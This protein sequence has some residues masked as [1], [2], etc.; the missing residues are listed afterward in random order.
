MKRILSLL[1]LLSFLLVQSVAA[2]DNKY[3]SAKNSKATHLSKQEIEENIILEEKVMTEDEYNK[4]TEE[5]IKK[6]VTYSNYEGLIETIYKGLDEVKDEIDITEYCNNIDDTD[7]NLLMSYYFSVLREYP[8]I[9]YGDNK[10]SVSYSYYP[11][12]KKISVCKLKIRY[13]DTKE[14]IYNMRGKFNI[15]VK[16]IEENYLRD[17]DD[18]LKLQYIIHDYILANTSYDYDNYVNDTVPKISYNAYGALVEGVAVCEGYSK[19]A[20]LLLNLSNIESG[21]IISTEMNHGW[22]YVNING[23]YYHMDITWDDSTPEKNRSVYNYFNLSD[24]EI[25][26]DHTWNSDLYPQCTSDKF[27]F[28]R[29]NNSDNMTRIDERIY[30]FNNNNLY[31]VNLYGDNIKNEHNNINGRCLINRGNELFFIDGNNVIKYN[32]IDNT[33]SV[34]YEGNESINKIYI[35]GGEIYILDSKGEHVLDISILGD[36]NY[37]GVINQVDLSLL[38]LRYGQTNSESNWNCI[39]DLNNDNIIDIFDITKLAKM[40]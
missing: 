40:Y 1:T 18:K 35:K 37:D 22:N 31:S 4:Y 20:K 19:A 13:I 2:Y 23:S 16:E 17:E 14:N 10:V 30:Y 25:S 8:E 39:Y 15:K 33:Y 26:K 9:F 24:N 29:K 3:S 38:A 5:K 32:T 27:N 21:I 34:I 28:L 36:F 6:I 7:F 12:S 11:S